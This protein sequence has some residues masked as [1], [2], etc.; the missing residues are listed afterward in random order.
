MSNGEALASCALGACIGPFPLSVTA[1]DGAFGCLTQYQALD[2]QTMSIRVF[3]ARHGAPAIASRWMPLQPASRRLAFMVLLATALPG[4]QSWRPPA[5]ETESAAS[6]AAGISESIVFHVEGAPVDEPGDPGTLTFAEAV[7]QSVLTDPGIQAALARVRIALADAKQ[8]RLLPNPVLNLALRF[9]QSGG[10]AVIEASLAQDL[11]SILKMPK[12]SSAADHRLRKASAEAISITVDAVAEVQER[13]VSVQALEQLLPVLEQRRLLGQKALDIAS[14]RLSVGEGTREDVTVLK[15]Q[16]VELE[17]EIA[18]ATQELRDERLRLARLIGRPSGSAAWKLEA[19]VPPTLTDTPEAAW[20]DAGLRSRSEIQ[21]RSWALAALGDEL[22]LT[23]LLPF[24]GTSAG[25]SA[26]RA[27]DNWSVGPEVSIPI[28]VFDM[29]QARSERVQAQQIEARHELVLAKRQ[30][31]EDVR[32]S[33]EAL[34]QTRDNVKRV[35]DELIPLQEQRRSL[36]DASFKAG[37]S[38]VTALFLAEQD[39]R[40]AQAKAV[41]LDRKT[42]IAAIRLQRAVGGPGPAT[43]LTAPSQKQGP[44]ASIDP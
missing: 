19:W 26:E 21:E 9:P 30:V 24:E 27:D 39:L 37:Q 41:D 22:S 34:A 15:T 4:C 17:V 3:R 7:R 38:D 23:R 33:W 6:R 14:A 8:A 1:W 25:V 20:I 31:I 43:A 13:Y 2:N 18:E 5:L 16:R 12:Q 29:G 28:P 10:Q 36:A 35:R 42:T 40:A 11:I 44:S 32:R